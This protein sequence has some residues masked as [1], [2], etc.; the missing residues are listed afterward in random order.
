MNI[1]PGV[2]EDLR[3]QKNRTPLQQGLSNSSYEFY[4]VG[5]PTQRQLREHVHIPHW[6]GRLKS[7]KCQERTW[8]YTKRQG[9]NYKAKIG[10]QCGRRTVI[11]TMIC[12]QHL[13]DR[14]NLFI[15]DSNITHR[16]G[17]LLE[18]IGKGLFTVVDEADP[19]AIIFRAGEVILYYYGFPLTDQEY[20]HKYGEFTAPYTVGSKTRPDAP[21][22]D[23]ALFRSVAALAN[24][25]PEH[26]CNANFEARYPTAD[27]TGPFQY[28]IVASKNIKGGR[29]IY[30]NYGRTYRINRAG[31][32]DHITQSARKKPPDFF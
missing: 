22:V 20:E 32:A 31:S 8:V 16:V 23:S 30:V 7:I 18:P 15:D 14:H 26:S 3:R 11:G 29:E 12:W 2:R 27:H 5:R 6:H 17:H 9:V 4:Y 19:D 24:H 25:R 10:K 21:L 13:K 1:P 28:A